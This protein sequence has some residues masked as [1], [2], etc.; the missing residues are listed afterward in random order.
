MEPPVAALRWRCRR[1]MKEL[2][3]LLEAYL[4]R[5]YD[6]ADAGCRSAFR[7]LLRY[8]DPEILDLLLGRSTPTEGPITD[9][10]TRLRCMAGHPA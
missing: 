5:D 2:D 6:D 9:V 4:E 7:E 10:I 8:Q 1:G 3:L